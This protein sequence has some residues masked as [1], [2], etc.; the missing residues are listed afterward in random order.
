M[1]QAGSKEERSFCYR[2]RRGERIEEFIGIFSLRS[3]YY[4]RVRIFSSNGKYIT[5]AV[6]Y[7]I[8]NSNPL[9]SFTGL[10]R[11]SL[12]LTIA[13]SVIKLHRVVRG[14]PWRVPWMR[15]Q[16]CPKNFVSSSLSTE[17]NRSLFFSQNKSSCPS[18]Q[19]FD[20]KNTFSKSNTN[21]E[22]RCKIEWEKNKRILGTPPILSFRSNSSFQ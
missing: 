18:F 11:S 6:A 5:V 13:I 19:R 22:C 10:P 16:S 2:S 4:K 7:Q 3:Y 15:R 14:Y 21:L 8:G 12:V 20:R 17:S 1:R 9:P